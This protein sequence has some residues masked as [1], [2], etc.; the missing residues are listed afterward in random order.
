MKT[1]GLNSY[2]IENI[3]CDIPSDFDYETDEESKDEP[4]EYPHLD[5]SQYVTKNIDIEVMDVDEEDEATIVIDANFSG[6]HDNS[7]VP[8]GTQMS[9]TKRKWKK[10]PEPATDT[11]F[12]VTE[13]EKDIAIST[14]LEAFLEFFDKDLIERICFE[15]NL[16]SV[17]RGKPASISE[18]DIKVFLGINI[19]LGYH[20]LPQL[21][22]YWSNRRDLGVAP[23]KEAMSRHRFQTILTNLHVNDNS[24][25]DLTKKD[26]LFKI[27]PLLEHLNKRFIEKRLFKEYLSID[28][29]TILFKGRSSLK[30]YNPMKPIKRGFKLWC[31][32]DDKGYIYKT[33]VY[34]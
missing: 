23:I 1:K 10:K 15:T 31:L 26:K 16:K 11:A 5:Y 21:T 24:K 9:T 8:P 20:S 4:V 29:S 6:E 27:R 32:A 17:Q 28:E 25:M 19:I 7:P 33:D 13:T 2:E 18:E 14:P 34:T 12:K 30:Q 22:H 3:L